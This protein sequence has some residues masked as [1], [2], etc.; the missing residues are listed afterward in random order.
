MKK[1]A[2]RTSYDRPKQET[3]AKIL[4]DLLGTIRHQFCPDMPVKQW[5]E[6][7]RFFKRV[8]T[9]GASYLNKRGVT[10]PPE[11]YQA[12]YQ[13]IFQGIKQHGQTGAVGYWPG[14]LLVAVQKHFDHHGDEYYEEGKSIRSLAEQTLL[15][16]RRAQDAPR[17][18]DSV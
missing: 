13:D 18:V 5:C 6:S 2:K 14:Y 3:P 10:L 8:L 7:Q 1:P 11:R 12:I 17:G 9:E 15:A 4:H 16:C